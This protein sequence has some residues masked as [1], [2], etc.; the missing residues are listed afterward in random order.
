[1]KR[2]LMALAIGISAERRWS[3]PQ[4]LRRSGRSP[5]ISRGHSERQDNQLTQSRSA[6][7]NLNG[8][9]RKIVETLL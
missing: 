2:L 5:R 8:S 3:C 6:R 1:M 4:P 9:L 7:H